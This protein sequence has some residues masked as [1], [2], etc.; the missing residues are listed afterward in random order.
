[1]KEEKWIASMKKELWKLYT[2]CRCIFRLKENS[3]EN[4]R[5]NTHWIFLRCKYTRIFFLQKD[6]DSELSFRWRHCCITQQL[7]Q[8]PIVA[9]QL[10]RLYSKVSVIEGLLD[11]SVMPEIASHIKSLKVSNFHLFVLHCI[12][13]IISDNVD[14]F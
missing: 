10:G 4:K 11:R 2:L 12:K 14:Y 5:N 3:Q 8:K 7:L 9:C 1:M 6:K 13:L